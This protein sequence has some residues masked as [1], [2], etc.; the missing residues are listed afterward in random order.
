MTP[1]S[2]PVLT[3]AEMRAAEVASGVPLDALMERAGTALA[4]AVMRFCGGSEV[5]VLCGPG[6]NGGDGYVAARI[7]TSRGIG[8]RVA[9]SGK[10]TTALSQAAAAAWT[11]GVEL[12]IDA[13]SAPI[14]VDALFGT[15]VTRALGPEISQPLRRLAAAASF[16]IAADLPS[17]A[18]SDD[19]CD[20]GAAR[21]HLTIAFAAAKPGH[22]LQPAAATCGKVL[23]ADI[24]IDVASRAQVLARPA[25]SPP[26]PN[27]NKY[28]RGMVA[29]VPGDMPGAATL[30]V[31]AAARIAGYTILCGKGDVPA[32]AVRRGFDAVLGDNRL[33]AMLIGPGLS[34]SLGNRQKLAAAMASSVPLVLDAGALGLTTPEHIATRSA[35]TIL[36][37]HQGE[38]DRLF[39]ASTGSKIDRA[40][41]AA[42]R[43]QATVIFKGAD[44]VIASPDGRVT[45]APAA[46][47]WLATAGTGDVLA[48]IVAGLLGCRLAPYDAACAAVWLHGETA[49]RAGPALIADDL[50]QHLPDA[51][52]ACL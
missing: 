17:G 25:L 52:A 43:S 46:S 10:P 39:G 45:L 11:G 4:D 44:T 51:L 49:R 37:P 8:V 23:I 18:G 2:G 34:D 47:P 35:T 7:L 13:N 40:R 14:L 1:L 20:Y 41:D 15:G 28:S 29:V 27:D 33:S 22:L 16:V 38:F 9:A 31:S 12:L 21:A 36:T 24:G 50:A 30:G 26:D 48:G 5:L 6:N 42:H 3:A 32:A 19:G